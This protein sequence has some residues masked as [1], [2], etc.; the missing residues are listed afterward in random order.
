[1]RPNLTSFLPDIQS[2]Y[3]EYLNDLR[4]LQCPSSPSYIPNNWH[5]GE[6][7]ANPVDPCHRTNDCFAQGRVDSYAYFGWTILDDYVVMPGADPNTKSPDSVANQPFYDAMLFDILTARFM[8]SWPNNS[9]EVYDQDYTFEDAGPEATEHR[10]YRLRE[11]IERFFVTDINNAAADACSQSA[12]P[13]MWDRIATDI[14]RD[15]FNHLPGGANVLYL[16]GHVDFVTFPSAHP[17]TRVFA[18]LLTQLYSAMCP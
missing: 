8:D 14:S 17:V 9:A 15:G 13:I 12:I 1:M 18:Y 10:L 16:D 11:G 2:L 5:F 6:D 4:V 7:A 3:P